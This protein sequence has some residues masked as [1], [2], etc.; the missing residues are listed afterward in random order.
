M[1]SG[2]RFEGVKPPYNFGKY[3]RSCGT[4]LSISEGPSGW[5]QCRF[6]KIWFRPECP[7]PVLAKPTANVLCPRPWNLRTSEGEDSKQWLAV[8]IWHSQMLPEN[9]ETLR[10][11]MFTFIGGWC[12]FAINPASAPESPMIE[13]MPEQPEVREVSGQWSSKMLRD[14]DDGQSSS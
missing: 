2:M 8:W 5:G 6:W 11:P 1:L 14:G 9:D 10:V 4:S 12:M 3:K 13:A 7:P